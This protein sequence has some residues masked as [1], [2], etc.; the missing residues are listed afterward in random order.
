MASDPFTFED[1][2]IQ[3]PKGAV[4]GAHRRSLRWRDRLI[5]ALTQSARRPYIYPLYTPSGQQVLEESPADHPH[6]NGVWVGADHVHCRFPLDGGRHEDGTYNFYVN[7]VFQGRAAGR[8]ETVSLA[9]HAIDERRFEIVWGAPEGRILAREQ[10]RI[11]VRA[12]ENAH[13]V[14]FTSELQPTEWPLLL[15]PTRHAYFGLRIAESMR[16]TAGG[17]L[18]DAAGARDQDEV[19]AGAASWVDYSGPLAAGA[20]A[21]VAILAGTGFDPPAWFATDWGVVQL[22]P[23]A[24]APRLLAP[25]ESVIQSM[26]L[27]VHDG[28]GD[29]AKLTVL[30]AEMPG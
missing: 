14:D 13:L 6:H 26:R 23:F 12:G 19:L 20:V 28:G 30:Q 25:D 17:Q 24:V 10:R 29:A 2:T 7:E 11:T 8:I 15:G 16:V 4:A 9:G 5:L 22:N 1:D 21:G 18:V 3:L 27:V